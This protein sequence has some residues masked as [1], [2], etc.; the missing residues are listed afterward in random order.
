ML[1][2]FLVEEALITVFL[3]TSEALISV[4]KDELNLVFLTLKVG[5][6]SS[7]EITQSVAVQCGGCDHISTRCDCPD[8]IECINCVRAN[9]R[10]N[11]KLDTIHSPMDFNVC[12]V[13]QRQVMINRNRINFSKK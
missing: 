10:L 2:F 6:T 11:L 3:K 4:D 8:K 1:M 12:T 9:E 13:Y 5:N 7:E